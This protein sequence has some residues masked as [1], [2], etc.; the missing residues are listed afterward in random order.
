MK[1]VAIWARVD[2]ADV[3]IIERALPKYGWRASVLRH[4][5]HALAE[6]LRDAPGTMPSHA[7]LHAYASAALDQYGHDG[8]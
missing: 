1:P 2:A 5:V 7:D 6:R 8:D 3:E 4:V